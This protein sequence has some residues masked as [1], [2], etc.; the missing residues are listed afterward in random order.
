M[1]RSHLP[2]QPQPPALAD[3]GGVVL[4][5]LTHEPI[6]VLC[7]DDNVDAADSLNTLLRMTGFV[8]KACHDARAALELVAHFRPEACVL[9]IS[10]PGMDGYELAR[11]LRG[12]EWGKELYL[13]AV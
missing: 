4:A 5:P 3:A 7:V 1:T 8:T 11:E 2:F 9:D 12:S 6:R 10:M 13:I